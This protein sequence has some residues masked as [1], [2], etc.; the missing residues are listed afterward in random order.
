[1]P[2]ETACLDCASPKVTE[3]KGE[4]ACV[5]CDPGRVYS[6]PSECTTCQ[7]GTT[8]LLADINYII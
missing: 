1:M 3:S 5:Y 8:S 7:P 4:I 6:S 2:G